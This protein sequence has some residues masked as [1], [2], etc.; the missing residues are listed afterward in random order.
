ML[1]LESTLGEQCIEG[2][3]EVHSK[4]RGP[5]S[6]GDYISGWRSR[7]AKNYKGGD[8]FISLPRGEQYRAA[9]N[10]HQLWFLLLLRG[11]SL[12]TFNPA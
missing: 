2:P 6:P 1:P 5:H 3:T 7:I 11:H 12:T 10:C 9:D 8:S 4:G